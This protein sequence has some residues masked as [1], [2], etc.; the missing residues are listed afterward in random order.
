MTGLIEQG[1]VIGDT[2]PAGDIASGEKTFSMTGKNIG[3]LLNAKNVTWG[4][5]EGG[6]TTRD[7]PI[8]APTAS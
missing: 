1:S 8:S 2:D 7:K 6:S 5:F 3:D 4:W